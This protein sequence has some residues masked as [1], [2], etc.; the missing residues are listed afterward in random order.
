MKVRLVGKYLGAFLGPLAGG[1]QW[2]LAISKFVQRNS[3]MVH[4]KLGLLKNQNAYNTQC[5][6]VL[7]YLMQFSWRHKNVSVQERK[8]LQLL[9]HGPWNALPSNILPQL[10]DVKEKQNFVSIDA[11]NV[12]AL[13]RTATSKQSTTYSNLL[14]IAAELETMAIIRIS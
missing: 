6:S 4:S 11:M 1:V 7:S 8:M 13:Y 10:M 3:Q 2:Q 5:A 14:E 12:A 9:T